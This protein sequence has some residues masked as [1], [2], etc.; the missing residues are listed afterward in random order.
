MKHLHV[1]KAA[2]VLALALFASAPVNAD[3]HADE[4]AQVFHRCQGCHEIGPDAKRK[5]GPHLNE[6]FGR[7][8]GSIEGFRYSRAMAAAGDNGLIWTDDRLDAFL[9][10]PRDIVP[11]TRM[12]FNGI[13]SAEDR[14][15]LIIF[16]HTLTPA[17]GM[18]TA[19]LEPSDPE[20]PPQITGIVGDVAYGQYLSSGCVTCHQLDG[21]D[22]GIPS[23]IGWPAPAMV[24]VLHAYRNKNRGNAVM[25]QQTAPLG[26]EEI[27][28]LAAF[29]ETL[30]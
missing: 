1:L 19:H 29:F 17:T 6:I 28:A 3:G 30:E 23:I 20:L 14:A 18:G 7:Q 16:L 8:A 26:N 5:V 11:G 12:S 13:R 27:A 21:A 24:T 15:A 22:S 2:V 25:Q 10:R 9:T 4:G